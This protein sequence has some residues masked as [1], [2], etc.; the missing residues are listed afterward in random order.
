[1]SHCAL[2]PPSPACTDSACAACPAGKGDA[3]SQLDT[4]TRIQIVKQ[5]YRDEWLLDDSPVRYIKTCTEICSDWGGACPAMS[6]A[7]CASL[8][9]SF[10][11]PTP[12]SPCR[13]KN[14]NHRP[15]Q[16][17]LSPQAQPPR[18]ADCSKREC[19]LSG[20]QCPARPVSVELGVERGVIGDRG[21]HREHK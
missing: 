3:A 13:R 16:T 2:D 9:R 12:S 20:R 21:G 18:L 8:C 14:P 7:V 4:N 15:Y 5:L 17:H 10:P 19:R 1:M 11:W 6:S